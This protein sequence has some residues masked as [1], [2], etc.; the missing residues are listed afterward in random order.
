VSTELD[1]VLLES[2]AAQ[3]KLQQKRGLISREALLIKLT[4]LAGRE[5][6][7][8]LPDLEGPLLEAEDFSNKSACMLTEE[9]LCSRYD[10]QIARLQIAAAQIDEKGAGREAF[11]T[12]DLVATQGKVPEIGSDRGLGSRVYLHASL[13]LYQGGRVRNERQRACHIRQQLE[14]SLTQMERMVAAEVEAYVVAL[15][16]CQNCIG[17]ME[18]IKGG[19]DQILSLSRQQYEMG[20]SSAS[21]LITAEQTLLSHSLALHALERDLAQAELNLEQ[22]VRCGAPFF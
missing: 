4:A 2:F 5:C 17:E 16:S 10:S 8:V 18:Q 1:V 7:E 6:G 19:A 15:Y 9:A 20:V 11:P 13:P 22:A 14:A 21:D 3:N 12:V